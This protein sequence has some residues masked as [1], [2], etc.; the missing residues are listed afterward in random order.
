MS[1]PSAPL[2]I[3]HHK[4][5]MTEEEPPKYDQCSHESVASCVKFTEGTNVIHEEP[6]KQEFTSSCLQL[7]KSAL[8]TEFAQI[9]A[10]Y[11]SSKREITDWYDGELVDMEEEKRKREHD[12]KE[13]TDRAL[14]DL[15]IKR[16]LQVKRFVAY[17]NKDE[18]DDEDV[19]EDDDEDDDDDD[20]GDVD[21]DVDV[22]QRHWVVRLLNSIF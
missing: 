9:Q 4:F 8:E 6:N 20:D 17:M 12:V 16:S 13:T 5:G 10:T 7:V 1:I 14:H 22:D 11:V 3:H 15:K 21:V 18:D 2:V 19:D